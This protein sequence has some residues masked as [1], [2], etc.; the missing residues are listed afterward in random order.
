MVR[1]WVT[2]RTKKTKLMD[3][4]LFFFFNE[5][6]KETDYI[7]ERRVGREKR[8][9]ALRIQKRQ[10]PDLWVAVVHLRYGPSKHLTMWMNS[11]QFAMSVSSFPLDL[12]ML[13]VCAY[14]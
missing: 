2:A 5:I 11:I 4:V 7:P 12:E 9:W 14:D 10:Q 8:A 13:H 3:K 1:T 6:R